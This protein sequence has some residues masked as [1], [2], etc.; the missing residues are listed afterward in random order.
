[1][2]FIFFQI[3]EANEEIVGNGYT[4]YN[5]AQIDIFVYFSH[6]FITIPPLSWINAGHRQ[7]VKILG[8]QIKLKFLL[9][10]SIIKIFIYRLSN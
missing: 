1:M 2:I 5:W 9:C 6:H 8:K 4:F 3:H 7:G 10:I